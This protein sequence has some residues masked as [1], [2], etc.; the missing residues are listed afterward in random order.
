MTRRVV[1]SFEYALLCNPRDCVDVVLVN[2]AKDTCLAST[3][4]PS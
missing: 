1:I 4:L 2:L 3:V